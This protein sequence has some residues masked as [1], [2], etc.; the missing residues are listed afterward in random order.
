M[1]AGTMI[2]ED[3]ETPFEDSAA[4][5]EARKPGP[6]LKSKAINW[7]EYRPASLRPVLRTPATRYSASQRITN[8]PDMAERRQSDRVKDD[9][10][11]VLSLVFPTAAMT[12]VFEETSVFNLSVFGGTTN[13]TVPVNVIDKL[14]KEQHYCRVQFTG[15]GLPARLLGRIMWVLPETRRGK[16][17]YRIGVRFDTPCSDD[18]AKLQD[19]L[20]HQQ[21]LQ[22]HETSKSNAWA[23][24]Q[25]NNG[26][27][28]RLFGR[29]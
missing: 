28:F 4:E 10:R 19:Y 29:E 6:Q 9:L 21:R 18:T 11:I 2:G 13:I 20:E 15:D 14:L 26:G 23:A 16:G 12:P 24:S 17:T 1:A 3:H 27:R 5:I 8:L 7:W 25:R 22:P